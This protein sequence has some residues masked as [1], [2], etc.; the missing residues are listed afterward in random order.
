MIL[1]EQA[2]PTQRLAPG[3]EPVR[4]ILG[5]LLSQ[6]PLQLRHD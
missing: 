1:P 2:Q 5:D 3:D 6:I 4:M